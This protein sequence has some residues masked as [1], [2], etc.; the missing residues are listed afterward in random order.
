VLFTTWKNFRFDSS[1]YKNYKPLPDDYR[2][3]SL[4]DGQ[5]GDQLIYASR[6]RGP[7]S[8]S[9]HDWNVTTTPTDI[10]FDA[11]EAKME[12]LMKEGDVEP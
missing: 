10:T 11:A 3:E 9:G 4:Y 1:G 2:T 5:T 7:A 12:T 6:E 8:A